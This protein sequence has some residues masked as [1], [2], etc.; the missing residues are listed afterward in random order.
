MLDH[1]PVSTLRNIY[2][3]M[4]AKTV[5]VFVLGAAAGVALTALMLRKGNQQPAEKHVKR[6]SPD[7]ADPEYL[8]LKQE[9]LVRVYQ[10]FGEE[11]MATITNAYVVVLGVGGVGSNVVNMLVR[12]GVRRLR[13]VDFDRVS[14]SSLSRH[15]YATLEDVGT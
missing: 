11:K 1:S 4:E 15:A 7:P 6:S 14:L 5:G 9:L 10:Y 2:L 13:I 3:V 8:A 12:S